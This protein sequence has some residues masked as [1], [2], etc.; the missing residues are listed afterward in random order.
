MYQGYFFEKSGKLLGKKDETLVRQSCIYL[1]SL[2]QGHATKILVTFWTFF[3]VTAKTL[4]NSG[5]LIIGK[6]FLPRYVH[7]STNELLR[8]LH[9]SW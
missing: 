7:D 8:F 9:E 5:P 2:Y 1:A 4:V 6:F 3:C